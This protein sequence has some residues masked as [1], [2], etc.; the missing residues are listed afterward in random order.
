MLVNI[1]LNLALFNQMQGDEGLVGAGLAERRR[2][3]ALCLWI[4]G[5]PLFATRQSA[6]KH[7]VEGR[8]YKDLL[9]CWFKCSR[10]IDGHMKDW[11]RR[12]HSRRAVIAV[13][14]QRETEDSKKKR[15]GVI[16]V[17]ILTGGLSGRGLTSHVTLS[18]QGHSLRQ[19]YPF[20]IGS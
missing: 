16:E 4:Q 6:I 1:S 20:L 5:Q 2:T 14:I 19:W 18:K 17:I 10:C 7:V 15:G 13:E 8:T 11:P 12:C 3:F 9:G